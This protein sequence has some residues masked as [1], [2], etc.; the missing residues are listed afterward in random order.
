[1]NLSI[2]FKSGVLNVY[3]IIVAVF[4]YESRMKV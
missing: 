1:M 4:R 3:P 2:I